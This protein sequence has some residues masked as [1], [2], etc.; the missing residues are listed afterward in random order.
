MGRLFTSGGEMGSTDGTDGALWDSADTNGTLTLDS[1]YFR[2]GSKGTLFYMGN[3]QR[4]V[5]A[6]QVAS[7]STSTKYLRAAY[8]FH[9]FHDNATAPRILA[10]TTSAGAVIAQIKVTSS[11]YLQLWSNTAQIGSNSAQLST[12]QW[13]VLGLSA[14]GDGSNAAGKLGSTTFA[15][16]SGTNQTYADS[17]YVGVPS[18]LTTTPDFAFT[19]DD[20]AVNDTAGSYET[21]WPD[22]NGKIVQVV[23]NGAGSYAQGARGGT[24][25]GSD[26][27]QVDEAPPND[28]TDYYVLESNNERFYCQATATGIGASDT[29]KL[30]AVACRHYPA[31]GTSLPTTTK[32]GIISSGTEAQ[33]ATRSL[34]TQVWQTNGTSAPRLQEPFY[35]DPNGSVAW[36][37]TTIDAVEIGVQCV[38][39]APDCRYSTIW[40]LVEYVPYVAPTGAVRIVGDGHTLGGP[41]TAR[42]LGAENMGG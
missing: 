20:V 32:L 41:Y 6:K 3:G 34:G 27:G 17:V 31:T 10:I 35:L 9:S 29:V 38:D 24:D 30:I 36:T 14:A 19:I 26:Y 7:S 11:G 40:G 33:S 4:A 37:Q 42:L 21:S 28:G 39:A 13:Y 2:S 1:S 22:V 15:S 18:N 23:P 25:S 8:Y 16:G 5:L 12:G